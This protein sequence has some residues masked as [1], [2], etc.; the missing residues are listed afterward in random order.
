L[1]IAYRV[2]RYEA[3]K[4]LFYILLRHIVPLVEV[5]IN[6]IGPCYKHLLSITS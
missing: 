6:K 1:F 3:A 2:F 4:R 5:D